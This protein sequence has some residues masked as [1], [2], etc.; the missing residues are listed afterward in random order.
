M[1]ETTS[2]KLT[3]GAN[4]TAVA[5]DGQVAARRTQYVR[6]L[7]SPLSKDGTSAL[8]KDETIGFISLYLTVG[9]GDIDDEEAD[10]ISDAADPARDAGLEVSAGGYLGSQLS[11][12]STR[13][14]EIVG[15]VAAMI[16][17]VFVLG[18]VMAMVMPIG[19]ALL[20]VFS[21][22]AVVGVVGTVIV[23]PSIAPTLAIMLGLGVGVDYSLFIVTR[24]RRLLEDGHPDPGGGRAGRGDL[25]RRRRL[26]RQHGD[27]LAALPLFRRDPAG[28]RPRLLVGDRGGRGDRRGADVPPRGPDAARR[29]ASTR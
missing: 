13:L 15:I 21:G 8:S 1:L 24:Y 2:G 17:L 26:R 23:V 3:E 7:V 4:R 27:P 18:T 14:S 5:E 22:L 19:T 20:G 29:P 6:D 11:E 16:V 9:S 10:S 12:P 25:R 28:A